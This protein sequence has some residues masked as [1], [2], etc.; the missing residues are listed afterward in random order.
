M[1][2]MAEEKSKTELLREKLM[3]DPKTIKKLDAEEIKKADEFCEDYK[4]FL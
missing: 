4:A 2:P 3:N 1:I